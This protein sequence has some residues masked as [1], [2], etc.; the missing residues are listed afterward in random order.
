MAGAAHGAHGFHRRADHSE[1]ASLRVY[2][3]QIDLLDGSQGF[4]R[5]GVAAQY[6]QTASAVEEMAHGLQC[7]LIDHIERA[8]AVRSTRVVAKV[9]IVPFGHES[10]YALEYGQTSVAGV[11]NAYGTWCGSRE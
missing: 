9:K 4:G 7:E 1:H 8:R 3:G 11:E 10:A 6:D 5:S 2:A